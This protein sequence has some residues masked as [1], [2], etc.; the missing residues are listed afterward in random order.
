MGRF[1][2]DLSSRD[3][4]VEPGDDFFRYANGAWLDSYTLQPDEMRYGTFVAL[5]YRSE[6]QVK[7][8]IQEAATGSPQPG[9]VE[10]K[11]GDYYASYMDMA[12]RDRRQLEPIGTELERID[13]ITDRAALVQA[14]GRAAVDATAAPFS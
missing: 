5:R 7:A 8:I 1:G 12:E 10:Q 9:T 11:I 3:T 4:S 6:E 2:L 14:F 13:A